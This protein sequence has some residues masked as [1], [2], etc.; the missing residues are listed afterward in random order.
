MDKLNKTQ[1]EK[2]KRLQ[3]KAVRLIFNARKTSHTKELFKLSKITPTEYVYRN[4]SETSAS[5]QPEAIKDILFQNPNTCTIQLRSNDDTTKIKIK[6]EFK[7]GQCF[8]NILDTWNNS[9]S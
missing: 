4:V 9:E 5:D 8:Y 3:K 6:S 1:M 2:L 7:K